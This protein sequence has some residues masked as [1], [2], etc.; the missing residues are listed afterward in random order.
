MEVSSF[1][2]AKSNKIEFEIGL[3]RNRIGQ[4]MSYNSKELK[5]I[6]IILK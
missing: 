2:G 3:C 1:L 4:Y 5:I 6:P